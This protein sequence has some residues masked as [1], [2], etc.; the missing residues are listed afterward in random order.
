MGKGN[1]D[2]FSS[3]LSW[4]KPARFTDLSKRDEPLWLLAFN[5]EEPNRT[6]E[7]LPITSLAKPLL[8]TVRSFMNVFCFTFNIKSSYHPLR[9]DSI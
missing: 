2:N 9:K 6:R 8:N 5:S 7:L 3:R 1:E 4:V